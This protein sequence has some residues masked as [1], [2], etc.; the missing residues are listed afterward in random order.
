MMG[1]VDDR[2]RVGGGCSFPDQLVIFGQSVGDFDVEITRISLFAIF[3]KIGQFDAIAGGDA[4]PENLVKADLA[5]VKVAGN[6]ARRVVGGELVWLAV[7]SEFAMR[8]AVGK[9]ADRSTKVGCIGLPSVESVV[10]V[11]HIG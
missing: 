5:A 9:T 8:D 7:E 1:H 2:G 4:G 3:G 10:A 6:T 11:G